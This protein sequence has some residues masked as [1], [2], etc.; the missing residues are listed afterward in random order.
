MLDAVLAKQGNRLSSSQ[1]DHTGFSGKL[2]SRTCLLLQQAFC[3]A[4][5]QELR[6]FGDIE[7]VKGYLSCV[8]HNLSLRHAPYGPYG[9]LCASRPVCP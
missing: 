2:F 1:I 7:R 5:R 3:S 9:R 8:C 4:V 6:R